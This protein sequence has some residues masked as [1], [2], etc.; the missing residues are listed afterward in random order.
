MT[1]KQLIMSYIMMFLLTLATIYFIHEIIV[2][3]KNK[4]Q[5]R[6][7][8][9]VTCQGPKKTFKPENFISNYKEFI[10]ENTK[11]MTLFEIKEFKRN[12]E[13]ELVRMIG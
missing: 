5:K 2:R 8:K 1:E 3:I 11:G 12:V 9:Q 4:T 13:L 7:S 10:E 6:R